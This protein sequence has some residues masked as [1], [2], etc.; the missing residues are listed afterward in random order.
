MLLHEKKGPENRRNEVKL[1]PPPPLRRPLKHSMHSALQMKYENA[2][3]GWDFPEGIPE[4]FGKDPG[5]AFGAFLGIPL[6][7]TAGIPQTL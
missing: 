2:Q 1:P 6:E 5:N 3:Y 4:K 7:S